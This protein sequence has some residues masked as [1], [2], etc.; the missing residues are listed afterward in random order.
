MTKEQFRTRMN[1]GPLILDGAT[2]SNLIA[3]GMPRGVSTE[4]WTLEHPEVLIDLQRGYVDAGAQVVY[5]PTFQANRIGLEGRTLPRP[6]PALI[7]ELVGLS[8]E[9]AGGRAL[10]AGDVSSTGR[11]ALLEY[12][13][14]FDAYA[15]Q[16]A[17]LKEAGVDFII[18]ETLLSDEEGAVILDAAAGTGLPALCSLTVEADGGLLM[19][20]NIFDACASLEEAGADAVGINCSCG[21][22]Q[23]EA[24]VAGIR[25][26]VNVPVIAKPNAG[27]PEIT[28]TGAAVYSMG[29]EPFGVAM[30]RLYA[31]GATLL[32]GCCG[33]TP[34]HIRAMAR[35]VSSAGIMRKDESK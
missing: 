30:R 35:A 4:L 17:A 7:A 14:L 24:V 26:R 31:A 29:P 9:A 6:I 20:G 25:R 5:A 10:V 15:E 13:E 3:A 18:A 34:A 28:E 23:L 33:T 16:T 32:G 22:D 19:G 11:F 2:G 21:P 12:D 1:E 8:R 27:L